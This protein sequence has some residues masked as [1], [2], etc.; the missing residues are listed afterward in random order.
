ME[1]GDLI[2]FSC[3]ARGWPIPFVTFEKEEESLMDDLRF[4]FH[5][6]PE[7]AFTVSALVNL[8]FAEVNDT[9]D[10]ICL[11]IALESEEAGQ[12][13]ES[14]SLELLVSAYLRLTLIV[15][16]GSFV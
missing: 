15:N 7:E 10:Y 4:T 13:E 8:T 5:T 12:D 2:T 16:D 14:F 3:T 11:A 9:G 1:Y 6:I